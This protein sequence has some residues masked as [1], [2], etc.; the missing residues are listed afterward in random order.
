MHDGTGQARHR[1]HADAQNHVT[2]LGDR[3]ICQQALDVGLVDGHRGSADHR[4]GRQQRQNLGNDSGGENF[5]SAEDG[6]ENP[7]ESV[8]GDLG[9]RCRQEYRHRRRRIG[10]SVG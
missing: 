4:Q 6:E 1:D 10:I 5:H 9:S 3:G 8:N 7:N 2:D